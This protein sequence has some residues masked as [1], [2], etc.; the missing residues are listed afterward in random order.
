[1][2]PAPIAWLEYP[3]A[4]FPFYNGR[5]VWISGRQWYFVLA[6]TALGF[7]LL[8]SR[9]LAPSG[10]AAPYLAA[11]LFPA[12]PLVGLAMVAPSH[13]QALFRRVGLKEVGWMFGIAV[14]NIVVT[15]CIALSLGTM[16]AMNA[17][18]AVAG[19]ATLSTADRVLFFARTAPQLLGEEVVTILPFLAVLYLLSVKAGFS[20]RRSILGAW[21][22]SAALFGALHLPT[23]GWNF[24]QC[25]VVIGSARLVLSL[26][27]I[28]TKNIWVSTGAHIINDWTLFGV[29]MM[30][31]T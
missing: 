29:A 24:V 1:M 9:L 31:V 28:K 22:V 3:D 21:L 26:A 10:G 4:D 7:A 19:L 23:Y 25:F 15:I 12:V 5:P 20:R 13:W 30:G 18:A 11:V 8:T 27:F 17:N 16:G 6:M 2:S 14:L